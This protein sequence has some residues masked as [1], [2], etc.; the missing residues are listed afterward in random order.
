MQLCH[1]CCCGGK[2]N[3]VQIPYSQDSFSKIL[4]TFIVKKLAPDK[5][6][7]QEDHLFLSLYGST[8]IQSR[9]FLKNIENFVWFPKQYLFGFFILEKFW[10]GVSCFSITLF[11][12]SLLALTDRRNDRQRNKYTRLA[13]AGGTFFQLCCCVVS[14]F[15][16]GGKCRNLLYIILRWIVLGSSG[17]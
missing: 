15:G 1:F 4:R 10:T 7:I 2:V 13:W 16:S 17:K 11:Y 3:F 14:V 9:S 5:T 6:Y 8:T 12:F